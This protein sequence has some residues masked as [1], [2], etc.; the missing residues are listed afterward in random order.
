MTDPRIAFIGG[1]NMARSLIGGLVADGM[2]S[3]SIVVSDPDAEQR[4][5]LAD[6]FG[7]TTL[8]DNSAALTGVDAVVLAVK[9]QMLRQVAM[10]LV[11]NMPA[12]PPL[13]I[14]IAAGIRSDDL[15][16][17]LGGQ[18]PVVRSMPNTPALVRSGITGLYAR[19]D[20]SETQRNLAESILRAVGT[21]LWFEQET[22]LDAVTAVS[23][24]GPAYFFYVMEVMQR[25][26]EE[27]GLSRDAARLLTVE[28]AFGAARLAL[29]SQ[30]DPAS[31]R[32]QVTSPG[33]TTEQAINSLQQGRLEQIFKD[34]LQAAHRRATEL[35]E[36]LGGD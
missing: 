2:A 1:G 11:D 6:N 22:D 34:A 14:S 12:T 35:S 16:R 33:G 10:A 28:T 5:L 3:Q 9:P 26:G 32:Q 18:C 36:D 30:D 24:S 17:W 8:D 20:V 7:V 21:T 29:E 23:G 13:F 27:L 4:R 15:H 19:Q 31:L 25:A